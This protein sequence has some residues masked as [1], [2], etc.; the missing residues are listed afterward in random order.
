M[1]DRTLDE[2]VSLLTRNT[3]Q[4]V[5][6]EDQEGNPVISFRMYP[7]LLGQLRAALTPGMES[8]SG[9]SGSGR[10]SPLA[11]NAFDL[12]RRI[13]ETSTYQY[14]TFGGTHRLDATS[15]SKRIQF[16]AARATEDPATEKEATRMI[17]AWCLEIEALF[18]PEHRIELQGTCPHCGYAHR[19]VEDDGE[20][21]RKATLTVIPYDG[22]ALAS[23]GYCEATWEGRELHDLAKHLTRV[24]E[25]QL[26]ISE[27]SG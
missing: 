2:A 11:L 5:R 23:C 26:L 7:S 9:G 14:W 27:Q 16:W 21:V 6:T 4:S 24:D 17:N 22:G 13:D 10:P 19:L 18:N 20:L 12:L 3:P 1:T 15:I 25:G 8:G